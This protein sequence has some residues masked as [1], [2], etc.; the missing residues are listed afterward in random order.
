MRR[1][2]EYVFPRIGAEPVRTLT[3][4][5]VLDVLQRIEAKGRVETAH[6][7]KESLGAIFRYAVA[8]H[9]ATHD[10]A[11]ALKGALPSVKHKSFA[12]ITEP[13]R[14]AS[15]CGRFAATAGPRLCAWRCN[16]CR[17]CSCALASCAQAR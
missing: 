11:A 7:V 14:W 8:T 12:S 10:P 1:L 17:W 13:K 5:Q 2:E 16:C 3:G 15:C 9:R 4:P 6:R